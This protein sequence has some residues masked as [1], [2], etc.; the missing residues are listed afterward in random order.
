LRNFVYFITP[1]QPPPF[2]LKRC[3]IFDKRGGALTSLP[4]REGLREG[5]KMAHTFILVID[6]K[7]NEYRI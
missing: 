5:D 1:T 2:P 4:G 7:N 3:G 6:P